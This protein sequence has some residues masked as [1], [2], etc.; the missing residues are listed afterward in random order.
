LSTS[1][2]PADAPGPGEFY[3]VREY[4]LEDCGNK[5]FCGLISGVDV[6]ID[7]LAE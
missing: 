2:E 4:Q 6:V 7:T 3:G 5:G 1:T